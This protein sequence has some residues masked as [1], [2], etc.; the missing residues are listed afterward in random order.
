MLISSVKFCEQPEQLFH[1]DSLSI[2]SEALAGTRAR[3]DSEALDL[4]IELDLLSRSY[5]NSKMF[6]H[7]FHRD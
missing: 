5:Y 2:C 4:Q 1:R 7:V 6:S 3:G